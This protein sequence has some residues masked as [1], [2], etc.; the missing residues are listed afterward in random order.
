MDDGPKCISTFIKTIGT[1]N[2]VA[3]IGKVSSKTLRV[4]W[5]LPVNKYDFGNLEMKYRQMFIKDSGIFSNCVDSTIVIDMKYD[6]WKFSHQ[7]G[8]M[9]VA[10]LQNRFRV[11]NIEE[12]QAR[13]FFFLS[14]TVTDEQLEGY[15]KE[16]ME[17]FLNKS[18]Q[19]CKSHSD[20]FEGIM[21]GIL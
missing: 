20:D 13:L 3:P 11:F 18:Y 12:G 16:K 9:D 5:I 2:K 14:T 17:N 6:K 4:Y 1:V 10:Q 21:E 19:I 15:S 8:A 7:S